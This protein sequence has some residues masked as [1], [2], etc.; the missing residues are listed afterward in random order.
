V[1]ELL[2]LLNSILPVLGIVGVGYGIRRVGWLTAASDGSLMRVTI[3]LLTPCLIADTI[4]GN[5]AFGRAQNVWIPPVLGF[6]TT[7]AGMLVGWWTRG[8]VGA[9]GEATRERTYALSVGIC[10]YGYVP[11]P[12]AQVLFT[13]GTVGVLFVQNIGVE[14]AMWLIGLAVVSGRSWREGWRHL[15]N[16]PALAILGTLAL[17]ALVPREAIPTS[18]LVGTRLLGQC[19]IPLGLILIGATVADLLPE[20]RGEGGRQWRLVAVACA[21]RLGLVPA[22]ILALAWALP[23]SVEIRQVLLLHAAMPAAVFPI[24]MARHFGGDAGTAL[25]VVLGTSLASVVTMPLW[26]KLGMALLGV[27]GEP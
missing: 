13:T 15:A 6:V 18:V 19:A 21:V 5:A 17:N 11:L 25:R 12:L 3:N 23:V 20:L 7:A 16:P 2:V 26:L 27:G 24:V 1:K 9:K 10:N 4:L 14:L 22:G 8:A